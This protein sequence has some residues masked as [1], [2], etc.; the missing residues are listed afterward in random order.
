MSDKSELS[1]QEVFSNA[2]NFLPVVTLSTTTDF[3]VALVSACSL[4]LVTLWADAFS[5]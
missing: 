2:N 4:L 1:Y 5:T 3:E